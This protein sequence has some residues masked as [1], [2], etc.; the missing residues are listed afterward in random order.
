MEPLAVFNK[1]GLLKENKTAFAGLII[2]SFFVFIA[3]FAP[4][5]NPTILGNMEKL[6][7]LQVGNIFLVQMMLGRTYSAN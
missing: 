1:V 6:S 4:F 2:L 7:S 3:I 5:I